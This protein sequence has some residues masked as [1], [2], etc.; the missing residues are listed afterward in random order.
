MFGPPP[1]R[2]LR[3][4][5]FGAQVARTCVPTAQVSTPPPC[6]AEYATRG[7]AKTAGRFG[8]AGRTLAE[9]CRPSFLRAASPRKGGVRAAT[10]LENRS[11][12]RHNAYGT[13]HSTADFHIYRAV[14]Y[15]FGFFGVPWCGQPQIRCVPGRAFCERLH[16]NCFVPS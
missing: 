3:F 14:I 15:S 10:Q 7:S 5:R 1:A 6:R 13:E 11:G 16:R 9:I 12:S 2:E 8:A 4:G